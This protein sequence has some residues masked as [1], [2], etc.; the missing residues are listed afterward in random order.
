MRRR[1]SLTERLDI[2]WEDLEQLDNDMPQLTAADVVAWRMKRLD[3]ETALLSLEAIIKG[4][5]ALT[6]S[7]E[8]LTKVTRYHP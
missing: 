8:E 2:L 1:R 4:S 7:I 3:M 6:E 5:T